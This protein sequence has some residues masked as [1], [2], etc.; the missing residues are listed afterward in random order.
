VSTKGG[1]NAPVEIAYWTLARATPAIVAVLLLAC[2]NALAIPAPNDPDYGHQT[3]SGAALAVINYPMAL[4]DL[5]AT[6]LQDVR[7]AALDTGVDLTHP[8]LASRLVTFT[9]PVTVE[10][11]PGD[12]SD[13]GGTAPAG[14]HGWNFLGSWPDNDYADLYGAPG[15]ADPS[16]PSNAEGST[17]HGTAVTGIMAAAFNNGQGGVGV[18]PNARILAIRSC[19]DYDNCPAFVEPQALQF[20]AQQNARVVSMSWNM[21][22]SDFDNGGSKAAIEASTNTLFVAL[23]GGNGGAVLLPDSQRPCG[24]SASEPNVIC[25]STSS[26]TGGLD[27]GGYSPRIVDLAVPTEANFTT[28]NGG[29]YTT[30]G[31]ATSYASP[32]LAGAAAILFGL[33]PTA[34]PADVK[35]ALIDS[36]APSAAWSGKSVSGGMLDLDAAIKLF[37]QR[38]GIALVPD[39]NGGGDG[40]GGSGGGAPAP[41]LTSLSVVPGKV[42]V[43]VRGRRQSTHGTSFRYSLDRGADVLLDVQ[44]PLPGRLSGKSCVAPR[45]VPARVK[46]LQAQAAGK[47][48]A[49]WTTLS[50]LAVRGATAG[51]HQVSYSAEVHGRIIPVGSYRVVGAAVNAGGWSNVRDAGFAVVKRTVKARPGVRPSRSP[52]RAPDQTRRYPD[53]GAG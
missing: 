41:V 53:I 38:R 15:N 13:N 8:D 50:T 48:C 43:L 31:C 42:L 19:W 16:D 2:P 34:T 6:P 40:G 46:R 47:S 25:V 22:Q 24:L 37:A 10:P 12:G 28:V 11:F 5:G 29:S 1:T 51:V 27:C 26:P 49:R 7:V 18:A 23:A 44:Q 4:Q 17:G 9:A 30:T 45:A 36:A 20:A 3:A 39:A 35:A 21:D 32:T 33:D 52:L 14:A